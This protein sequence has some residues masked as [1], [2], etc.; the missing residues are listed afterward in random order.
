MPRNQ[1][2]KAPGQEGS[3]GSKSARTRD[4]ITAAAAHV[5]SRKGYS[6]TRLTDVADEAV[7]Q[8][9]AIYYYFPSR[10]DLIEEVIWTGIA[11]MRE[12]V[13]SVL[14]ALPPGTGP[15]ARIEAAVEAHLR[16]EL[17]ISDYTTAAIRNAGQIPEEIRLRYSAEASHYGDTWRKLLQ[18]AHNAGLLRSDIEPQAARML[19]MGALNYAAEW[20]NPRRDSLD[21]VVHTARSIVRHGLCAPEAAATETAEVATTRRARAV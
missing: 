2:A 11:H 13:D 4:R 18:D 1:S 3:G 8:A 17:E 20:W 9:P 16:Y 7:L 21:V 15:I 12:Y 19:V 5:L 10:E 14:A 6:G